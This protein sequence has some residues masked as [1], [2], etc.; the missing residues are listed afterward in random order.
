MMFK[1]LS[2]VLASFFLLVSP[3]VM[4]PVVNAATDICTW[5]GTTN[6]TWNTASNWSCSVDGAAVPEN[7][8]SLVFPAGASNINPMNNDIVGLNIDNVQVFGSGYTI[9]GNALSITPTG[10]DS[11]SLWGSNNNWAINTTINGVSTGATIRS[12]GTGNAITGT[13][14]LSMAA[15]LDTSLS[16]SSGNDLNMAAAISG[17]TNFFSTTTSGG[18]VRLGGINTFTTT[19][20]V[21]LYQHTVICES[22][23]CL[24]AATNDVDLMSGTNLLFDTSTTFTNDI[25]FEQSTA[26][27]ST[28]DQATTVS[29]N[30]AITA[31][32]GSAIIAPG[33]SAPLVLNGTLNLGNGTMN[34]G[35]SA[36]VVQNGIISGSGNIFSNHVLTIAGSNTYTGSTFI[37]PGARIVA[38]NNTSLGTTAEGTDIANGA[39]LVFESLPGDITIAENI[40]VSGNGD[41]GL[42]G[43]IVLYETAD[44]VTLN[45]TITLNGNTTFSNELAGSAQLNIQG[46][47]AG[48]GNLTLTDT[49]TTGTGGFIV[50]G[51][52]TYSGNTTISG[53]NLAVNSSTSIPN[54]TTV[55]VNASSVRSAQLLLPSNDY[56]QDGVSVELNNNGTFQGMYTAGADE[57]LDKITGNGRL[58][59]IGVITMLSNS[60]YSFSGELNF[61]GGS[62]TINKQ[63][64]GTFTLNGTTSGTPNP[65]LINGGLVAV[66]N[67]NYAAVPFT[68]NSGGTLKGSG[69]VGATTVNS[70]GTLNSGNSPGCMTLASLTLSSGST[71]TQEIAGSTACSQYDQTTVTGAAVLGNATLSIQSSVTP[72]DGTVFTILNAGSV[73]GTF[74]GLADNTVVT[75]GGIQYRI[76]Y[77]STAVT[78]TKVA[79][80][81]TGSPT[82]ADTGRGAAL[83]TFMG[84]ITVAG[85][86]VLSTKKI[87]SL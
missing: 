40:T 54:N 82:L 87:V 26:T 68:V 24:G 44:S 51:S 3:F 32:S 56:L 72:A 66:T 4:T 6:N 9:S 17:N 38:L 12:T 58:S 34:Y 86:L 52:N 53:G 85:A 64:T 83:Q 15:G 75:V 22:G 30:I 50:S 13:L 42:D 35:G 28:R 73:S 20:R 69:S 81:L 49:S 62:G 5:T 77:T 71:F 70:G 74:N 43:A 25:D 61:G 8:D 78:L 7:G 46:T 84:L 37:N 10:S 39:S 18:T 27:I 21:V 55:F 14:T 57:A 2:K 29:G 79:G 1:K 80:A 60:D 16:V 76:N 33:T 67:S 59:L 36:E 11:L 19:A 47:I 41:S 23:T 45:G 31:A 65:L 63:G 48:T